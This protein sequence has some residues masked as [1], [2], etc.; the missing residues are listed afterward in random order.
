MSSAFFP[1][2]AMECDSHKLLY[3]DG[4]KPIDERAKVNMG[5]A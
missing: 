4:V 5:R 1:C 3:R 2:Q